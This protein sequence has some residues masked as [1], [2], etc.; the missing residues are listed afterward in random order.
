MCSKCWGRE[1][2]ALSGGSESWP[3]QCVGCDYWNLQLREGHLIGSFERPRFWILCQL[4]FLHNIQLFSCFCVSYL[5]TT[6]TRSDCFF[7]TWEIL[8]NTW[9]SMKK[10]KHSKRKK[11]REDLKKKKKATF[12]NSKAFLYTRANQLE[13]VRLWIWRKSIKLFGTQE[14][15]NK[16]KYAVFLVGSPTTIY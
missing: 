3:W 5:L 8:I 10:G 4:L 14:D 12:K 9:T 7:G 1:K 2:L 16:Q 11:N 13:N 6:I 15:M